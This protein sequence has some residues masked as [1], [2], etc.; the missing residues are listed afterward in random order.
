MSLPGPGHPPG[1]R[2]PLEEVRTLT[3]MG[4]DSRVSVADGPF[5]RG[6]EPGEVP[7]GLTLRPWAGVE[8]G[9]VRLAEPMAL[10]CLSVC[11]SVQAPLVCGQ[12]WLR[13]APSWF[14]EPHG[15]GLGLYLISAH[16]DGNPYKI[17]LFLPSHA[18][19]ALERTRLDQ[20]APCQSL[21]ALLLVGV[22]PTCRVLTG[23]EAGLPLSPV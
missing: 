15:P 18:R 4:L 21:G 16:F 8:Q 19:G 13:E 6:R 5:P 12:L 20:A 2:R 7:D 22:I 9:A 10:P 14:Q 23:H 17:Q 3:Q 11:S 1:A